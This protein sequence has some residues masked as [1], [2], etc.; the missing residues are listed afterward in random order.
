MY[1]INQLEQE[2]ETT[3]GSQLSER[4]AMEN[5]MNVL[6]E[7]VRTA[8]REK[9]EIEQKSARQVLEYQLEESRLRREIERLKQGNMQAESG[10]ILEFESKIATL[11]RENATLIQTNQEIESE[12]GYMK[13]CLV[14]LEENISH[15]IGEKNKVEEA[16]TF[17]STENQRLASQSQELEA[18]AH[19]LQNELE[20]AMKG[21]KETQ[22]AQLEQESELYRVESE[23][24]VAKKVED[25]LSSELE[26]VKVIYS[27][28]V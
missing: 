28:F 23:L 24:E 2:L 5:S 21:L 6:R 12:K 15:L 4:N 19:M 11:A 22:S 3:K 25:R 1:R 8:M 14:E 10:V 26:E 27:L 18:H 20:K 17:Y 9:H 13:T 7:Q 16:C